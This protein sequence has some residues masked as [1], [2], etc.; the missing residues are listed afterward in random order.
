MR[1]LPSSREGRSGTPRVSCVCLEPSFLPPQSPL[2]FQATTG[3][4]PVTVCLTHVLDSYTNEIM[5]GVHI[6]HLLSVTQHHDS[7]IHPICCIYQ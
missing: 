4:L 1:S 6:L 3:L 5:Q 7:E 2:P